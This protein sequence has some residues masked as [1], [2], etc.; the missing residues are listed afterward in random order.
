MDQEECCAICFR[1]DSTDE[2]QIV[3][4]ESCNVAVHQICFGMT[5]VPE[6]PWLCAPCE[7]GATGD[8]RTCQLCFLD[9]AAAGVDRKRPVLSTLMVGAAGYVHVLC[10]LHIPEVVFEDAENWR[11]VNIGEDNMSSAERKSFRQR[12]KYTCRICHK[13]K[14]FKV[15]CGA[16]CNASFHPSCAYLKG[17]SF[18]EKDVEGC[19]DRNIFCL[20]SKCQRALKIYRGESVDDPN[21]NESLSKIAVKQSKQEKTNKKSRKRQRK[22]DKNSKKPSKRAKI[23]STSYK[24]GSDDSVYNVPDSEAEPSSDS[25]SEY[26]PVS[27]RSQLRKSSA[28]VVNLLSESDS[29]M[30]SESESDSESGSSAEKQRRLDQQK[31]NYDSAD[32]GTFIVYPEFKES[33]VKQ[34]GDLTRKQHAFER[35][36]KSIQRRIDRQ[37]AGVNT[38]VFRDLARFLEERGR[39][40]FSGLKILPTAFL[41]AGMNLSDHAMYLSHLESCLRDNVSELVVTLEARECKTVGAALKSLVCKIS[42]SAFQAHRNNPQSSSSSNAPAARR[43]ARSTR[44]CASAPVNYTEK[45]VRGQNHTRSKW[46]LP[47]RWTGNPTDVLREWYTSCYPETSPPIVVVLKNVESFITRTLRAFLDTLYT[48]AHAPWRDGR[49]TDRS[50]PRW[51]CLPFVLVIFGATSADDALDGILG[52]N[53]VPK[54]GVM[55]FRLPG[56]YDSYKSIS[57]ELLLSYS[58][59]MII[60]PRVFSC[61]QDSFFDNNLSVKSIVRLLHYMTRKHCF[62][63]KLSFLA[64][65]TDPKSPDTLESAL[66]RVQ[67]LSEDDLQDLRMVHSVQDAM[68]SWSRSE[69]TSDEFLKRKCSEWFRALSAHR[70][71]R[72]TAL[73]VLAAL[74]QRVLGRVFTENYLYP[75]LLRSGGSESVQKAFDRMRS[76]S[77][78]EI[79]LRELLSKLSIDMGESDIHAHRER[80]PAIDSIRLEFEK[81]VKEPRS[82]QQMV[83]GK[84]PMSIRQRRTMALKQA[85]ADIFVDIRKKL[86]SQIGDFIRTFLPPITSF[87]AHEIV[88]F[89]DPTTLQQ[90][91]SPKPM[92][93]LEKAMQRPESIL[94]CKCCNV[95]DGVSHSQEDIGILYSMYR[96]AG[97]MVSMYEWYETFCEDE[98]HPKAELECRFRRGVQALEFMG[99]IR[100]SNR[101]LDHIEKVINTIS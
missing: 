8:E 88:Y 54:L 28:A 20:A 38:N 18:E 65:S 92:A 59:P 2:N 66:E 84:A 37:V 25:G 19:L 50:D 75:E 36:W 7:D 6:G 83:S 46:E 4:C 42:E 29:E 57:K 44:A 63:Q 77:F 76:A 89:D 60:G 51:R 98:D 72:S 21:E 70:T 49:C 32:V 62:S 47:E 31:A 58:A 23:S 79:D 27:S 97:R 100:R 52:I 96:A 9:E 14:G 101:R 11:D 39:R 10:A 24:I 73:R 55:L 15:H 26:E 34:S 40:Q 48:E 71:Q 33:I 99:L 17:L 86:I 30:G 85:T 90:H 78:R 87:P 68:R 43:P 41:V 45:G 53:M 13:R 12:K 16:N 67:S 82:K 56:A 93:E 1:V 81:I 91:F 74:I 94:N 64:F 95:D 69:M 5:V 22:K 80:A 3:F 61:I 35:L